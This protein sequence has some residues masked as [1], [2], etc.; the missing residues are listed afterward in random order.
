[1]TSAFNVLVHVFWYPFSTL[2]LLVGRQKGHLACEKLGVGF[3]GGDNLTGA[4]HVFCCS[5]H[6]HLHHP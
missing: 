2:T 4:L 1:L 6:H 5:C 3:V